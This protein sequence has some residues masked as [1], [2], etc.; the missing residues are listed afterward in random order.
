MSRMF[1]LILS[2]SF[3]SCLQF[4][5]LAAYTSLYAF[6]DGVC[7]T[8][9]NIVAYPLSTNY[10]GHRSCNGRVW[11]EVL[12]QRQGLPYVPD[13]NWSFFGHYSPNLVSNVGK[14][15]A[16]PDV[17]TALFIV[18]VADADFVYAINHYAPYTTN[19]LA[20]WTNAINLSLSNYFTAIQILYAK[21]VRTLV[22]PNAVD[23]TKVPYYVG[24]SA[25]NKNFIRQRVV[26][27]NLG[28]TARLNQAR[29]AFTD[30]TLFAPDFYT[31]LEN[32][33]ARP[34]EYGLTNA[35]YDGQTIDALSDEVLTDKSLDGPGAD[36][37]FW[38]YLD[39]SARAQAV[40]ADVVHQLLA[41]A[42]I[43]GLSPLGASNRLDL[44]DLPLGLAGFVED[45]TNFV[46]WVPVYSIPDTDAPQM[47]LLP[48]AG[49]VR[50]YRLRFPFAWSW[51]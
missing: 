11:I 31:L 48:A 2:V 4:S 49:P 16:P 41:P 47:V 7:T 44:V 8:T 21:G 17:N 20:V 14:F 22:M 43:A 51:P 13:Q 29:A 46:D 35:L 24:L 37:I 32:I 42:R 36:Y 6:G 40:M 3:L 19:N 30:L 38:D 39:P 12:A 1:Q 34:G 23:L 9:S 26:E 50:F 18:W 27:F 10:Y 28:F 33:L 45:S 5:I 25:A 15:V